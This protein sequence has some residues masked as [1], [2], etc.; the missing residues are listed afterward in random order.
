VNDFEVYLPQGVQ[1]TL[2]V[3]DSSLYN[4]DFNSYSLSPLQSFATNS[5]NENIKYHILSSF[6]KATTSNN[7][8]GTENEEYVANLSKLAKEKINS[9]EWRLGVKKD[10]G[11][12]YAMIKD[13]MT[14]RNVSQISLD[15]RTVNQLGDLPDISAIQGQL[16]RISEQIESLNHLVE[17]V[18]QGQYN[19]RF[20]GF[21]SARQLL[22]EGLA[23][24][25][26]TIK[27][28]LLI[29]VALTANKAIAELMLSIHQDAEAFLDMNINKKAAQRID[30][31]L[32]SSIGYL[33]STV[34]LVIVTYTALGEKQSLFAAMQNYQSYLKQ[35]LLKEI[36]DDGKTLCWKLDNAHTGDGGKFEK[37]THSITD[38]ISTLIGFKNNQTLGGEVFEGISAEYMYNTEVQ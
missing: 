28:Q 34:Q 27:Q 15:K 38:N 13:A 1:A 21:F 26:N 36:D 11:E 4:Y 10:T 20:A 22:V 35:T 6:Y 3:H 18:E 16:A 37:L 29:N 30:N 17:R 2:N 31:L 7:K 9:G 8:N 24:S 25:D 19:D 32:Q 12:T 23:A 33:N 14:G 5:V